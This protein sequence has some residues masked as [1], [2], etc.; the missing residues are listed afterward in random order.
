MN[1]LI[2]HL[3]MP[4]TMQFGTKDPAEASKRFSKFPSNISPNHEREFAN[5]VLLLAGKPLAG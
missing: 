3:A 5:S 1:F 4:E 2:F